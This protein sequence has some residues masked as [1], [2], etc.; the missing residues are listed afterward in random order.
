M[1]VYL[2][3]LTIS[4]W[5]EDSFK[6]K[7]AMTRE[8]FSLYVSRKFRYIVKCQLITFAYSFDPDQDDP[9]LNPNC[10]TL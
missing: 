1:H 2:M 4:N 8:F 9:E 10:L 7:C 5:I 3:K 6:L